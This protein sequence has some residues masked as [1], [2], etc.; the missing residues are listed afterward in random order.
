MKNLYHG[1]KGLWQNFKTEHLPLD[2][3]SILEYNYY[4][5]AELQICRYA[6]LHNKMRIISLAN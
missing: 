2:I 6:E 1:K 4:R 3:L 5:Y